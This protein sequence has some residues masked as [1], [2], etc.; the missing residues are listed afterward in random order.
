MV[1]SDLPYLI[2]FQ[3]YARQD[4]SSQEMIFSRINYFHKRVERSF[5]GLAG[6]LLW[7]RK[8]SQSGETCVRAR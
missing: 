5:V 4:A 6:V 7:L 3:S 8:A 1:K 2:P